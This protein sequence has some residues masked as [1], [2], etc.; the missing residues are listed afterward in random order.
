MSPGMSRNT[1][2]SFIK[3]NV[4][5]YVAVDVPFCPSFHRDW[6][7]RF[8]VNFT[9]QQLFQGRGDDWVIATIATVAN[10]TY[11]TVYAQFPEQEIL[12]NT[13]TVGRVRE[14]LRTLTNKEWHVYRPFFW[15]DQRLALIKPLPFS[16]S[17]CDY[18]GS[19]PII[20]VTIIARNSI[21]YQDTIKHGFIIL[22]GIV[23]DGRLSEPVSIANYEGRDLQILAI[24]YANSLDAEFMRDLKKNQRRQLLRPFWIMIVFGIIIVAIKSLIRR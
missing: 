15:R 12:S 6:N 2:S 4:P 13:V 3:Q 7:R 11:E 1:H 22:D 23:Y 17:R 9:P 10:V 16:L 24:Y 21:K 8:M 5:W 18:T 14:V 19:E 20:I